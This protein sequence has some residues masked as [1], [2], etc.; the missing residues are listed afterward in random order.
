V[1]SQVSSGQ[2]RG[3]LEPKSQEGKTW[4]DTD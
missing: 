3:L 4:L 2:R 1:F